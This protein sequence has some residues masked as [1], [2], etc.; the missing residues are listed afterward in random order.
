MWYLCGS[1]SRCFERWTA[2]GGRGHA[3]GGAWLPGCG[4]VGGVVSASCVI[5]LL[6]L[7]MKQLQTLAD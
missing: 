4:H 2:R 6:W 5:R 1:R 7:L 3:R